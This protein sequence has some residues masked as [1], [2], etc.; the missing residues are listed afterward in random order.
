MA[1]GIIGIIVSVLIVII[2]AK[3]ERKNDTDCYCNN[4]EC[5]DYKICEE[6]N[7]K[8]DTEEE[9]NENNKKS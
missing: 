6:S 1:I 8:K 4:T 3:T 9:T 5:K 7:Y 2:L